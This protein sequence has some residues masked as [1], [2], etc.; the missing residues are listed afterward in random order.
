MLTARS[1]HLAAVAVLMASC[2][3]LQASEDSIP[4]T[5]LSALQIVDQIRIHDKVRTEELKRYT[6]LRHYTVEYNGF[7]TK[8]TA[9]MDVEVVYDAASGKKF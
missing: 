1:R 6:A 8:L 4:P 3:A 2:A 9:T 5:S 7:S